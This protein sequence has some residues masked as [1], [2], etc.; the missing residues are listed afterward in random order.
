MRLGRA[1][2][3][4]ATVAPLTQRTTP[5]HGRVAA[6]IPACAQRRF[7][8]GEPTVSQVAAPCAPRT[9]GS[10]ESAPHGAPTQPDLLRNSRGRPALA[11]QGP[12]RRMQRLPAAL[13]LHGA[14]RRRSWEVMRGHRHGHRPL[15]QRDGLLLPQSLDRVEC[16]ARQAEHLGQCLPELLQQMQA[17]RDLGRR[18]CPVPCAFGIGGRA[19]ARDHLPPRMCSEP[20]G[21]GLGRAIW[22]ERDRVVALQLNQH[23]AIRLALPQREVSHPKDCRQRE[24]RD[25]QPPEPAPQRGPAPPQ[26]PLMAEVHPGCAP[27]GDAK[28]NEALGAP[29]RAP[30]P[31]S[32]HSGKT[33]RKDAATTA[34]SAAKPLADAQLEVPPVLR[35]GQ[36]SQR[37]LR[38][39]V[40]VRRRGEA[41]RTGH[42]GLYRAHTQGALCRD[43]IDR[44]RLEAQRGGIR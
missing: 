44:Q 20:L 36:I 38:V 16:L 24:R 4:A 32:R 2:A 35:P 6:R 12:A 22:E 17:V 10:A 26:V 19:I 39:T 29:Q 41:Q 18:R 23:G 25:R 27:Q 43:V 33:F 15:R 40:E 11:V 42:A 9:G 13:A 34:G 30:G 14:L 21:Q 8:G 5:P 1:H 28:G 7:L 37:A 3:I 31:G